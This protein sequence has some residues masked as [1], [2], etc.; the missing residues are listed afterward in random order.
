MN[1]KLLVVLDEF[2]KLKKGKVKPQT[3]AGFAKIKSK[4]TRYTKKY[5]D[6]DMV[7]LNRKWFKHFVKTIV[8]GKIG[9][10]SNKTIMLYTTIITGFIKEAAANGYAVNNDYLYFKKILTDHKKSK[11]LK[12]ILSEEELLSMWECKE[13]TK[14]QDLVRD[15]FIFQCQTGL[16]YGDLCRIKKGNI[17]KKDKEFYLVDFTTQKRAV[18]ITIHLNS[19]CVFIIKKHCKR[20]KELSDKSFVFKNIPSV[21]NATGKLKA[22]GKQCKLNRPVY[23]SVAY[24]EKSTKRER[25]LHEAIGTHCARHTFASNYMMQGGF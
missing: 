2:I 3:M 22:I 12:A 5:G 7:D 4:L 16:R 20:F 19:I 24:G 15:L 18:E 13:L 23:D 25:K 8:T 11:T 9:K 6:L 10:C 1:P 17:V 14:T 21:N